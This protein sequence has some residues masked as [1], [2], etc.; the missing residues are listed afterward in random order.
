MCRSFLCLVKFIPKYLIVFEAI[1]RG[2]LIF[3][4]SL[5]LVYR[6]ATDPVA[7]KWMMNLQSENLLNL[8]ISC[9]IFGGGFYS[10]L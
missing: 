3:S 10:F 4:L 7:W 5:L 9:N 1:T 6:N 2:L 8:F